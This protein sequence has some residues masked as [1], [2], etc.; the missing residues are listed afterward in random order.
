MFCTLVAL[1]SDVKTVY[2]V[3]WCE[4][5]CIAL[6]LHEHLF[7]VKLESTIFFL[8]RCENC[9]YCT[10]VRVVMYCH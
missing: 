7:Y 9:V 1:L 2:I 6:S 3:H 5:G 8:I 4:L 10:L